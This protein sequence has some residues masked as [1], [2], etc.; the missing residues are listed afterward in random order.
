MPKNKRFRSAICGCLAAMI[1][2]LSACG[3]AAPDNGDA[4]AT[5]PD[6]Q[7]GE[8]P[9]PAPSEVEAVITNVDA[10]ASVLPT[11][12]VARLF[13]PIVLGTTVRD[14][15]DPELIAFTVRATL[16]QLHDGSRLDQV[17]NWYG[18]PYYN[19]KVALVPVHF[20]NRYGTS[21]YGEIVLPKRAAV[22]PGAGPFPTILALE[23]V[24][25]NV[26]MYRWWHQAFADAGYLVFA[27]DFAGQGHSGDR[28]EGDAGTNISDSEDA[29]TYLLDQSPVRSVI[30][31][32][33]VGVIGHSLG[34]ITTLGLQAVEPRLHAA[35]AAAPISEQSAPFDDNPIPT[36]IQTGDYDGPV[37]PIPLVN[38]AVV[39]PVYEKLEGDRAFIVSEASSHAQW[40]NYP[41]LPTAEWG[42]DIAGTYSVAWMDYELRHDPAALTVLRSAHPHLSYLWDSE[43]RIDDQVTVMRGDGPTLQ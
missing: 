40:T 11:A 23:G 28:V 25:T 38:P 2:V 6:W 43:T 24:N 29:L 21:L 8:N 7:T 10:L 17:Y 13:D 33:C 34:A 19:D 14:L 22:P 41:L 3:S 9:P 39:R 36:M 5:W 42:F 35:V 12:A 4:L 26:A 32:Q 27:F 20:E 18:N 15:T 16:A 31:R 37:A 30:D 1:V